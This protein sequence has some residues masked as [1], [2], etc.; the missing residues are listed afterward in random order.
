[1]TKTTGK[2]WKPEEREIYYAVMIGFFG[3]YV[4]LTT[5]T[6]G[7]ADKLC[8]KSGNCFRTKKEANEKLKAIRKILNTN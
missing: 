7:E 5:W 1:M 3:N 8:Y 4:T 6:E 2:R